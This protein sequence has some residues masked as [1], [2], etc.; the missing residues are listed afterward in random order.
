MCTDKC[1]IVMVNDDDDE[2]GEGITELDDFFTVICG[3][4]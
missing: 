4:D 1:S 2:L 3:R